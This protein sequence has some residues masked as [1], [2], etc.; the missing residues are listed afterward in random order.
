VRIKDIKVSGFGVWND[1]SVDALPGEVTLFYG[2]NEAGKT[3]LMQFV[4]AIL[5]GFSPERKKLYLPPVF[6]GDA[7][8][9]LYVENH[10]GDFT[11][12]RALDDDD[13]HIL[14]RP[15]IRSGT[16]GSRQGQHLLNVLLSG[17]DESIFNNVFAVGIRELQE[18]ATLN[19]TQAA[20]QLYNLSSGVD[21][22]SLV[23]VMR[24]LD[25]QRA[26]IWGADEENELTSLVAKRY[27][28]QGNVDELQR[29]TRRWSE[30]A[31]DQRSL[32]VDV[33]RFEERIQQLEYEGRTVEIAVQVK[34]KWQTLEKVTHELDAIGPI[35]DL[36]E[37]SLE[38][39]DLLNAD[40]AEQR[41]E[42]VPVKKR[43]HEFRQELAS[44]PINRSLW[45]HSARIEAMCEHGPWIRSLEEDLLRLNGELEASEIALLN[46]DEEFAAQGGVDVTS[47]PKVTPRVLQQLEAPAAAHRE[48]IK[49]RAISRKVRKKSQQDAENADDQLEFKL[50]GR[51][52]DDFDSALEQAVG[53]VKR[54]RRRIDIE[55][56]LEG[57]YRQAEDLRQEHQEK[58]DDQLLRVRLLAGVGAMF[59]FGFVMLMTGSVGWRVI[60]MST[61]FAWSI[62]SLG[63]FCIVL[64]VAWK[65][66]V[67]RATQ[68]ELDKC[69][70]RREAL[71]DEVELAVAERD[72]IERELPSSSGT[73][74]TQLTLAE[75]E[76]KELEALAPLHQ[77]RQKT[78]KRKHDAKRS[79]SSLDDQVR[80]ARG[81]WRRALRN[82]GL[83]ETLSHRHVRQIGSLH[84]KKAK[85]ESQLVDQRARLEKVQK[86]REAL[87]AR[88]RQ[89]NADIGLDVVSDDPQIQLSQ[90]ATAL[91]GQREMV[92]QRRE[93]QA[94]E[95]QVR[96]ELSDMLRRLRKSLRGREAMFA[97]ARV[98]DE[99]QLRDR[100]RLLARV[101]KLD[102]RHQ[103]LA[104]QI[105][106]IV[107]GHC[108]LEDVERELDSHETEALQQRW[109]T[110]I[111]HLQDTHTHLS[112]LYERRGEVNQEMKQ[113]AEYRGFAT[114]KL[115]LACVE[116]KVKRAIKQWRGL[117]VTAC[118]LETIREAYEA[119]RQ[120]ETLGEASV[121]LEKLTAGKYARIWTPLGKNELRIDDRQGKPMSLDVLSRGTREAVFLSLRLA[122]VAAYGRRG[123][124]LPMI[125]D[126][127]LVNLDIERARAAVEL[128]CQ[129]AKEGRQLLF[130][131]C[132][133]HI[134][135]MFVEAGVDVRILPA[136]GQPGLQIKPYLAE[137]TGVEADSPELVA[138][139]EDL[140]DEDLLDEESLDEEALDEEEVGEEYEVEAEDEYEI[141]GDGESPE[142]DADADDEMDQLSEEEDKYKIGIHVDEALE[143]EELG[144]VESRDK[145]KE[146]TPEIDLTE[147]F[148]MKQVVVSSEPIGV[149]DVAMNK[150]LVKVDEAVNDLNDA[151]P[152]QDTDW[153][154][155]RSRGLP[156]DAKEG[157]AA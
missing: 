131:T 26:A 138:A 117:A 63:T 100:G 141:E 70:R 19:D 15:V 72:S 134:Q 56:Q 7:G 132:H 3:T 43:R 14:G 97:Q 145:L 52:I 38:D 148:R 123:V 28:L 51:D 110:L 96:R 111:S 129:F 84:E 116:A 135:K 11:I 115:E 136:H 35:E 93:L 139:E 44:Q 112:Q 77:E 62:A 124:N 80:E 144:Q 91:A 61:E 133:D 156:K 98:T 12:E 30:L 150:P 149:E 102:G 68:E 46:Y 113:L 59:V 105:R 118:L 103:S 42:I 106:T 107:G 88:M 140:V 119:E 142:I 40:I 137:S 36:P 17:I 8:G 127:V 5:Y 57:F 146:V 71:A 95:K 27:R 21:R 18:L 76:L 154:W 45:E 125:L 155:E 58:L 66:F 13:D 82:A 153:W 85:V 151:L 6:G 99:E 90:L 60:T 23:E 86:D 16:N 24:T 55:D 108:P 94:K 121:Y 101:T 120:P 83:P 109:D 128:L 4:R 1:V 41:A 69:L 47:M 122:L 33:A 143:Q 22:V 50:H 73:L 147:F 67:E 87:L 114:A 89:L 75:K 29:Q 53:M 32:V 37:G 65:T 81:R 78:R 34:D 10:S 25:S 92:E 152:S 49:Q 9:T 104:E 79:S 48:A 39:L 74:N 2:R 54:L 31:R 126:D 64:S 20:E 157:N 130:F